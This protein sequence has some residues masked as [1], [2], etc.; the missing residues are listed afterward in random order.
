MHF[1]VGSREARARDV[2]ARAFTHDPLKRREG[3]GGGTA[4]GKTPRRFEGTQAVSMSTV[5]T[6]EE[7]ACLSMTIPGT[8]SPRM[9]FQTT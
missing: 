4:A 6:E 3:Y 1:P 2:V 8:N 7:N 9:T 5:S